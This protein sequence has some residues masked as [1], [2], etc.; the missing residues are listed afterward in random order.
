[1]W[2]KAHYVQTS[3]DK[4]L[5]NNFLCLCDKSWL[6]S[7]SFIE[8]IHIHPFRYDSVKSSWHNK[9]LF[10]AYLGK[11]S[12]HVAF[13]VRTNFSRFDSLDQC[14][15]LFNFPWQ[16]LLKEW[17]LV[18]NW[19]VLD[20][21]YPRVWDLRHC[22]LDQR[23]NCSDLYRRKNTQIES[24]DGIFILWLPHVGHLSP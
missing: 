20:I 2:G 9:R 13:Y 5:K 16:S 10:Q 7:L 17:L 12:F 22:D 15:G 8:S 4:I 6:V 21:Y 24:I 3:F 18:G 1:M 11:Y 19:F 23:L 14:G